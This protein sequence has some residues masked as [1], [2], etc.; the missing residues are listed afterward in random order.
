MTHC[1]F[2]VC[3]QVGSGLTELRQEEVRVVSKAA[4]TTR[5]IDYFTL[6]GA[7]R[8]ERLGIV[9]RAHGNENAHVM[10]TTV[11]LPAEL[12][13]KKRVVFCIV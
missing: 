5:R 7:L 8:N 4:R 1:I 3:S 13:N 2:F 6:P 9:R 12:F 10:R 11:A